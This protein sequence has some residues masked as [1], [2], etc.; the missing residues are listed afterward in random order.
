MRNLFCVCLFAML[1]AGCED[2]DKGSVR[3]HRDGRLLDVSVADGSLLDEGLDL[4]VVDSEV[5]SDVAV[6]DAEVLVDASV[7]AEVVVDSNLPDLEVVDV[8]D[9]S[10]ADAGLDLGSDD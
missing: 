5:E 2:D 4:E 3:R 7:D 6:L 1:L 9:A 10:L 8:V